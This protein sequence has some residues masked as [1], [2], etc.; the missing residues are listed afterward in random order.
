MSGGTLSTAANLV[1][2][3]RADGMLRAYRAT[4][5][6][7]LWE[8]Q[9]DPG[10]LAAPMTYTVEGTQYVAVL[11]GL[12]GPSALGN[13]PLG[14]GRVGPGRLLAFALDGKATLT[15]PDRTPPP[16][17]MP[18]FQVQASRA[19]LTQGRALYAQFCSRCHGGD[20]ASGGSVPD[21]RYAS[22]AI[23]ETFEDVVRGGVRRQFGM[24]SFAEDVTSEQLR[25]IQAYV[26]ERAR[27]SAR[28]AAP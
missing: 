22:T 15:I 3:G 5:G 20:V 6:E 7:V 24:P 23:H 11:A 8:F 17:P 10:I 21:L 28:V 1:F 16:V 18:T 14:K 25:T 13:R 2:Q 9:A 26:L 12:G 27:E 4:D 19:D